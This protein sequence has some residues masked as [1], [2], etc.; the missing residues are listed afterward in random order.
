M[1]G[2]VIIDIIIFYRGNNQLQTTKLITNLETRKCNV[3][4]YKQSPLPHRTLFLWK[5]TI[6][7]MNKRKRR[8][9]KI[10]H[11]ISDFL[12]NRNKN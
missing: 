11:G 1:G 5:F 7:K 4:P 3:Q 12:P 10:V 2:F 8:K 6:Q 9:K